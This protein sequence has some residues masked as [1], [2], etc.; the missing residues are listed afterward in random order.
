MKKLR[1]LLL[2]LL[3]L[4]LIFPLTLVSCGNGK[5]D[6]ES[7]EIKIG[8]LKG[9]TGIGAS[10]LKKDSDDKVTT[11]KYDISF[12]ETANVKNLTAD[13]ING[14]VDIAALPINTAASLYNETGKVQVIAANALGV[15]SIIGKDDVSTIADLKGTVIHTTGQAATPEYILNYVLQKNG[16]TPG[17]DVTIKFYAD[18]TKAAAGAIAEGGVAMLPEPATTATLAKNITLKL[19]FNVTEEWNKVS[20]TKL[21]QGVLVVNKEFAKNHKAALDNFINEYKTS[22]GFMTSLATIEQAAALTVEYGLLANTTIAK[23]SM[24]RSGITCITGK[25]MKSD[26]SA[27]LGVLFNANADSIKGKLPEKDFY[28]V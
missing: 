11:G 12:Y 10:K 23:T 9:A 25:E 24:L 26:V 22:I 16:L 1:S 5:E 4:T 21:V 3:C 19:L 8:V 7:T 13:I 17:T 6:I 2:I 15:L 14:T 27:M 18:G 28:Y 20:E